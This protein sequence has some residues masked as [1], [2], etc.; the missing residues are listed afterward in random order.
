MT[1]GNKEERTDGKSLEAL[2]D[3]LGS[4]DDDTRVTARRSLA[5]MGKPAVPTLTE[6]LKNKKYLIRW[7]AAKALNEIG[8]P[9][10]APALVNALEDEEFD[11]RWIAAE[12]LI[13]LNIY[14]VV[15]LLQALEKRGDSTL[16]REG[17]HHVFH[18]LAKGALRKYLGPVLDVLEDTQPGEA[19]PMAAFRALESLDQM[20]R[21]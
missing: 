12:G 3:N 1:P 6:A 14:G 17:A 19:I 10:A 13:K 21:R 11:V 20:K 4:T 16:L 7:E 9:A 2:V 15:P 8:D 5:A 18:D